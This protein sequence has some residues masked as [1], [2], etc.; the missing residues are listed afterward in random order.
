MNS[1]HIKTALLAY[2]RFRKQWPYLATEVGGYSADVL[3]SDGAALVEAEVK[4]SRYDLLADFRKPKHVHC[5]RA[6]VTSE[7][8]PNK[9]Y[10]AVP[11][12]LETIALETII[13]KAPRY[14]LMVIGE[15]RVDDCVRV[16]RK[17]ERI[18]SRPISA[19]AL[20]KI[21]LRASSDLV[22][23]YIKHE[24][25]AQALRGYL[26][27]SKRFVDQEMREQ[28][29]AIDAEAEEEEESDAG[30]EDP[31]RDAQDLVGER[32]AQGG[33]QEG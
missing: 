2:F 32:A 33:A 3:A 12:H 24:L 30:A 26:D 9:F 8:T 10:F 31:E 25:E 21:V 27:Q 29:E 20:T 28:Q 4:V 6:D 7:W 15:G 11:P 14:G 18:H 13:A 19:F 1:L 22:T 5:A 17:A 23:L 16:A